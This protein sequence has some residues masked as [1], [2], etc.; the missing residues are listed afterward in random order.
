VV[1]TF[2]QLDIINFRAAVQRQ[3]FRHRR[4]I[5]IGWSACGTS[6]SAFGVTLELSLPCPPRYAVRVGRRERES[7]IRNILRPEN[8]LFIYLQILTNGSRF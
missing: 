2:R 4:Q 7:G 8:G 1:K 5:H 6:G 3:F